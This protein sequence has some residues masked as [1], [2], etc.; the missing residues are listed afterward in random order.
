MRNQ[1]AFKVYGDYALFTDPVTKMGGEK[2]T[3]QIP[4]YQALKGIT[5]SIYWKPSITYFID[6]VR[7]VNPIQMESKGIRPMKY[8][9]SSASDL[10]YYTYLKQ[11]CYEV[12]VHFEFNPHRPDLQQDW[13][14]HKHYQILKRAIKAGGRRDIYLGTRE[15][16]GY[17]EPVDFGETEGFY[18]NYGELHFGTMVH[19]LSYP[20]ETGKEEL[21]VRLWQ[22]IMEDGVIR[23]PRPEIC[24]IVRPLRK[25]QMKP[26]SIED[27]ESV[28]E[29]A[30]ALEVKE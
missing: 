3:Y 9:D 10:A 23:F 2:M 27:I 25:M 5:E 26:F 7:V 28:D 6:E 16:Q 21:A 18:D 20:D 19:G 30:E 11:S 4:T 13:N 1:V 12:K 15:C 17:V 29:L 8:S 24:E 22:P 14:E